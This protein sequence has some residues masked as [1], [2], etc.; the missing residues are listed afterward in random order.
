MEEARLSVVHGSERSMHENES[1]PEALF[2]SALVDSKSYIP[3]A[4]GIRDEQLKGHRPVHEFCMKYQ[5]EAKT[6]PPHELLFSKF[7]AFPYLADVSPAW[8]ATQL[9]EAHTNR[10]LRKAMTQAS[11]SIADDAN[12]EAID[13][14]K[15]AIS[16]VAPAV[17]NGVDVADMSILEEV[18]NIEM[19]P[20]PD[21]TISSL[22]G[23]IAPGDLWYVAARLGI[24][25]SWRLV[26]HAIAAAEAGWDVAYFSLEMPAKSV[27]DRIHR[28]AL[29]D[30]KKPWFELD[31]KTRG[32][33]MEKWAHKSGTISVFDPTSGRCDAAVVG[34]VAAPRTLVIVD[35]IGLMY[36]NNG[37]R[38]IEDWRSAATISNQLKEVALEQNVPIIAA[39]QINRAGDKENGMPSAAN[40]AQSDALG[41]DADA[42]V[43]I[44]RYSRRVVMNSLTKYRHGES[45]ARWYSQFEPGKGL[46]HDITPEKANTLRAEDEEAEQL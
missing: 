7:P 17:S 45:G 30:W 5:E 25:K 6:A 22:T 43:T 44:K 32:E 37:Q 38:S 40:L 23:G 41:Q 21:G 20:V 12:Q 33:L 16:A 24:G 8:A 13:I 2:I 1:S 9:A 31:L 42:L 4:Y 15:N 19:C 14:L 27:L 18:A 34:A 36:T 26:Q 35:Y 29:R 10:M 39:A 11:K 46:L 28:I 3:G